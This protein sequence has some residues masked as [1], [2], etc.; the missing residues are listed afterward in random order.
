MEERIADSKSK[1]GVEAVA[2]FLLSQ[3]ALVLW[4]RD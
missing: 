4:N 2:L 1:S 3:V